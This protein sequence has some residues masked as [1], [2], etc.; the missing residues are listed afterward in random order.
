[1]ARHYTIPA[2][3]IWILG[4]ILILLLLLFIMLADRTSRSLFLLMGL[5]NGL[6]AGIFQGLFFCMGLM[7]GRE[8][9]PSRIPETM[10]QARICDEILAGEKTFKTRLDKVYYHSGGNWTRLDGR[11]QVY[12]EREDRCYELV[13]GDC[14][15][16]S[17][18]LLRYEDPV[19]PFEFNYGAYQ[20]AKGVFY[21]LYLDSAS[22]VPSP[23]HAARGVQIRS[24]RIRRTLM[25]R[26]DRNIEGPDERAILYS[27]LLG[28]RAELG[29]EVKQ[30][31]VRSGSMHILA[32]SGLHVGILYLLPALLIRKI[33]G[34]VTGRLLAT[35][36]LL[37]LLWSYAMLTGLSPSVVRAV[38]M[39]SVHRV[40]ILTGRRT[41]IF[42]VLSLTAFL[43]VLSR[44]AIIFEAG[45]QLSFAAVAGIAGFQ[46]PLYNM[47]PAKGW[48][49]RRTW[50]LVT[51]SL[52]AQLATAPL[53]LYY[54]HQFS[55]VFLLS[56]L[57]VI[58][59]ATVI[60][61]V[62][63]AFILLSSLG[64]YPLSGILEWLTSLLNGITHLV[65]R[66][67]G[68]FSENI[69]LVPI[70]VFLL[71]FALILAG[72]FMR[73]R[74]VAVFQALMVSVAVLLV[75]SGIREHRVR[76]HEAFYV[77]SIPGE[78]AISFIRGREH[79]LYRGGMIRGDSLQIPYALCNFSVRHRLSSPVFLP[80]QSGLEHCRIDTGGVRL[81]FTVFKDHRIL[82]IRQLPVYPPDGTARL[83]TD[84]LVLVD[85]VSCNLDSWKHVF[86]PG[87]IIVDGSNHSRYHV[88]M[89]RACIHHGIPFHS[90]EK[91]GFYVY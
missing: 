91:D 33:R 9:E 12:F 31:F 20:R 74:K 81:L 82:I 60:L 35:L 3:I 47:I 45:F 65:G 53:S 73:S 90:T 18:K 10:L 30:Q 49:A 16:G 14:I 48:M 11:V 4:G 19:N 39:C 13:P 77:F 61:Y 40:A 89:E 54:F 66:I 57:V 70:Q 22:W 88:E 2:I 55:N 83:K 38:T 24:K 27:L 23:A 8:D 15:C 78:S 58:P 86:K 56:N 76:S 32:V 80:G 64:L 42:H 79:S 26:I 50:Q 41:G 6:L 34:S 67:P 17:G 29:Q 84:I 75:A 36:A 71:Y 44:P 21:H 28:Y 59:L 46:K 72:L 5:R 62:G 69:T 25:D 52:A 1:M 87:L 7:M 63:L 85:N 68:G 51:V 37:A 43:M